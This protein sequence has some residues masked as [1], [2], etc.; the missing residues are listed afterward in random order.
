[1]V[2]RVPSVHKGQLVRKV[3]LVHRAHKVQQEPVVNRALPGLREQLG[4]RVSAD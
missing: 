1:M 4:L 3:Q 2:R